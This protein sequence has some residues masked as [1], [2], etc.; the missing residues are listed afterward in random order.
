VNDA[1]IEAAA[2]TLYDFAWNSDPND[3]TCGRQSFADAGK[4]AKEHYREWARVILTAGET[5]EPQ[6]VYRSARG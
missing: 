2:E 3:P 1:R 6:H 4:P 5:G